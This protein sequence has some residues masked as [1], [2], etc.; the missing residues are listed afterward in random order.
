[1]P[2]EGLMVRNVG[3]KFCTHW[4]CILTLTLAVLVYLMCKLSNG[5]SCSYISMGKIFNRSLHGLVRLPSRNRRRFTLPFPGRSPLQHGSFNIPCSRPTH[6]KKQIH[7]INI[8]PNKTTKQWI[9]ITNFHVLYFSSV[10]MTDWNKPG[11]KY[12]LDQLDWEF[13]KC[14]RRMD[15]SLHFQ[16]ARFSTFSHEQTHK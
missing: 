13:T 10:H 2:E 3:N 5:V 7:I 4:I 16:I 6:A 1:M 15:Q 9:I 8:I 11:T 12:W 14:S